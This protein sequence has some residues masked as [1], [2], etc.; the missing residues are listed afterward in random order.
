MGRSAEWRSHANPI[1]RFGSEAHNPFRSGPFEAHVEMRPDGDI[2]RISAKNP[3]GAA[4]PDYALTAD[5]AIGSG[6]RGKSYL[7]LQ[8]GALWQSPISW[9]ASGQRWNLSP[10]FDLGNGGRWAINS[11]CLFCHVN[12]V[13][14]VAGA[15]NRYSEP[16]LSLGQATIG[17]ER[18]HGPGQLHV[19]ERSAGGK[20]A[21][22]DTSIVNPHHLSANLRASVCE[23]CHLEG[24]ER[25]TRRG[26]DAYEFRPGLPFE[27]FVTVFIR[28]P[29]AA[30]VHHSVGQFEQMESSRCFTASKAQM[31]CTSC[32][33][34]HKT[35][36]P[37]ER[38]QF[39]RER[40]LTCHK[41]EG[42]SAPQPARQAKT[43]SCI[44]C[45][46]PRSDSSNIAHASVTDHRIARRPAVVPSTRALSPGTVPLLAYRTGTNAPSEAERERDLG[47]VLARLAFKV[48]PSAVGVRR[49]VA[50]FAIE[51]LT[52]SLEVWPGDDSAWSSLS[53][54]Y[55]V[56]GERSERFRAASIATK[57]APESETA[58]MELAE[59]A[60]AYG[61]FDDAIA[62]ASTVI[63]MSPT[64]VEPYFI[65]ASTHIRLKNWEQ[66]ENDCRT[67]LGVHPLHPQAHMMLAVC[68]YHR[69]DR[70]GSRKAI[71][72]AAGLATNPQQLSMILDWYQRETR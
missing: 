44:A 15:V 63:R 56:N 68:R 39:Y 32:H 49:S 2:H 27:Q 10:G 4:L 61:K 41:P 34:P 36:L 12:Q 65:R 9:Y 53:V 7:S 60:L 26:R 35:P 29:D 22:I 58:L 51:R 70:D 64:T 3:S 69:G 46:M 66:A 57:L 8:N 23:Q 72:T 45:H 43:D 17:C 40:C 16:L 37:A 33:D 71:D 13:K 55:G 38:D 5:L 59:A 50:S 18:C 42:C 30:N 24:Q 28:H 54:A 11:E 31:G 1:E 52:R 19:S 14:P 67:A 25:V 47:V 48:P 62:A 20:V 21:G 6:T